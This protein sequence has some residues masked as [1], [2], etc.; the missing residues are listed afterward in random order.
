MP[1][2]TQ[3]ARFSHLS[4]SGGRHDHVFFQ[5]ESKTED[6]RSVA[7]CLKELGAIENSSG[8]RVN[9]DFSLPVAKKFVYTTVLPHKVESFR[10][11]E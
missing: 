9:V 11:T 4:F 3:G 8:F 5:M 7:S 6:S 1:P 2:Q 10:A